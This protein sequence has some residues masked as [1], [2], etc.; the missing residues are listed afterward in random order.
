MKY[1]MLLCTIVLVA[2]KETK[3]A[4]PDVTEA[5]QTELANFDWL[6]GNWQRTNDDQGKQTFE[7]WSKVNDRQYAG[8][9][10]TMQANDTV[11]IERIQLVHKNDV[12]TFEVTGRDQKAPT[13]FELTS[14]DDNSFSCKNDENEFPNV[15]EY[16]GNNNELNA[17]ISGSDMMIPFDFIK[18]P[19]H[20]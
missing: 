6:L 14:F 5:Q 16:T 20:N 4:T 15:I 11:F 18:S 19:Q 8:L 9:G 13:V 12:W 3:D 2:C 17:V 7:Q 1:V 10:F